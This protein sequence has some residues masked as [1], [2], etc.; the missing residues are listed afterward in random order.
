MRRRGDRGSATVWVAM[1][2]AAVGLVFGSV[3]AM[4]RAVEA[5]HRAGAAADLAALA[6]ADHWT[7]GPEPACAW[8]TRVA[9]AQGAVAVRCALHGETAMV[10]ATSGSA[11]LQAS[12][13][14]RAGP[15]GPTGRSSSPPLQERRPR[16]ISPSG[17]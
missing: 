2:L 17:D 15:A 5:K 14:A 10:T 6:A 7:E 16:Q 11:P 12:V 1:A 8:A 13:S 9:R 4:A 3:L